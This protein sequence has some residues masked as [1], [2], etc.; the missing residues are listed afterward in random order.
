MNNLSRHKGTAE[1]ESCDGSVFLFTRLLI[2]YFSIT[3]DETTAVSKLWWEPI[4]PW[5]ITYYSAIPSTK[6]EQQT[7]TNRRSFHYSINFT[8]LVATLSNISSRV[9]TNQGRQR[10]GK[11]PFGPQTSRFS[12][13]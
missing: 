5:T 3:V 4:F 10:S 6:S 1:N 2:N 8:K 7:N 13:L 9:E 12:I 11:E